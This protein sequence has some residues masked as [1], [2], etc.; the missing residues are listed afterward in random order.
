MQLKTIS[1]LFF[2]ALG[3]ATS[4]SA[5]CQQKQVELTKFNSRTVPPG[6]EWVI[7]NDKSYSAIFSDGVFESGTACNAAFHSTPSY[8]F[9]IIYKK[10]SLARETI[11]F[12]FKQV[13][14]INDNVFSIQPYMFINDVSQ[15][16][17]SLTWL[18]QKQEIVFKPGTTVWTYGCLTNILINIR[19]LT[20]DKPITPVARPKTVQSLTAKTY[21]S[22]TQSNYGEGIHDTELTTS[23]NQVLITFSKNLIEFSYPKHE[24]ENLKIVLTDKE[25]INGIDQ[26]DYL[27]SDGPIKEVYYAKE[28]SKIQVDYKSGA[29]IIYDVVAIRNKVK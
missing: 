13:N 8:I 9:G 4:R 14:Q 19:P 24:K 1:Q 17:Y 15:V 12:T 27:L 7:S 21:L 29:R 23:H 16:S 10:D 11:G 20:N 28:S 25:Y 5:N 2:L 26:Q 3:V 18:F 6:E 22:N